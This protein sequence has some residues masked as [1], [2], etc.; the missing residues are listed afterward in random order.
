MLK[1]VWLLRRKDTNPLACFI[2]PERDPESSDIRYK[3]RGYTLDG[4]HFVPDEQWESMDYDKL[5]ECKVL[6]HWGQAT[7]SL[8][9][10]TAAEGFVKQWQRRDDDEFIMVEFQ[11]A[12][13]KLARCV[14]CD[15]VPVLR[16]REK[17]QGLAAGYWGW[18]PTLDCQCGPVRGTKRLAGMAWNAQQ[19]E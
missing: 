7:T 4:R 14:H 8:M 1:T 3:F 12:V 6:L 5:Y 10:K 17:V 13:P 11:E 2:K 18:C 9:E 19:G 16:Y 15:E